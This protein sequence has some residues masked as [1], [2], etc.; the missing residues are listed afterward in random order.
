[1]QKDHTEKKSQVS[2]TAPSAF[3]AEKKEKKK[4]SFSETLLKVSTSIS[5]PVRRLIYR[6][7]YELSSYPLTYC[8]R[9]HPKRLTKPPTFKLHT[10]EKKTSF[11]TSAWPI[12]QFLKYAPQHAPLI[13][14]AYL[15]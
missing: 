7:I 3:P 4:S 12:K 9:G 1:M 13:N 14:S 11:P 15:R 5:K 8:I 6:Y 2:N 10:K